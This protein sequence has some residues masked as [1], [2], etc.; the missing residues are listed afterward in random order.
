MFHDFVFG[1]ESIGIVPQIGQ[2]K[3]ARCIKKMKHHLKKAF[4]ESSYSIFVKLGKTNFM[5]GQ[6][7]VYATEIRRLTTLFKFRGGG[8]RKHS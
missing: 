1:G 6:V 2:S 7:D 8:G 3:P 4:T 5:R